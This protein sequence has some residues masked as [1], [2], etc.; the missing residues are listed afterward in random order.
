MYIDL[1]NLA[2]DQAYAFEFTVSGDDSLYAE[3]GIT[4]GDISVNGSYM[5]HDTKVFV[6][7]VILTEISY[8]CD[9]CLAS[10]NDRLK[11]PFYEVFE[12][13]GEY[14]INDNIIE[15]N[16][17]AW[18]AIILNMPQQLLCKDECKGLCPKCGCDRNTKECHC[19]EDTD[20]KNPFAILKSITGGAKNGST[21]K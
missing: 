14:S 12:K 7:A 19:E 8:T 5:R 9:K 21:K 17:A 2:D 18:D 15:L 4:F 10:S 11:I 13:D 20:D 3:R 1:K 16:K 6:E